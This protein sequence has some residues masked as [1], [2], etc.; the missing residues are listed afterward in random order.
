MFVSFGTINDHINDRFD[1]SAIGVPGYI[2]SL[3]C[4]AIFA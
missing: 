3:R 1:Q 4:N 2:C